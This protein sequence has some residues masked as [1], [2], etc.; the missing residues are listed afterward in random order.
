MAVVDGSG[1]PI[2][3]MVSSAQPAEIKLAEP[4]LATIKVAIKRGRPKC[5]PKELVADKGYDSQPFRERL[6]RRGIKPCIPKRV[7]KKA[8]RGRKPKL[9]SYSER[10]QVERTF[11]WIENF[12]RLQTRYERLVGVYRGLL[13]LAV[14]LICISSLVSG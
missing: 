4:T 6:R 11:S 5:R 14:T 7:F 9:A 2:G 12:R 10:W 13:Y 1:I 8:K 3:L